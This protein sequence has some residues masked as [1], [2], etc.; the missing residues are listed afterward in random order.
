MKRANDDTSARVYAYGCGAP[1]AGMEAILAEHTLQRAMWD[2][3]CHADNRAER[4]KL[5]LAAADPD[6]GPLVAVLDRFNAE[7]SAAV[8]DRRAARQ[9]ARSKVDTPDLDARIAELSDARKAARKA[10][11]PLMSAW[12]KNHKP[13]LAEIGKAFHADAKQIR[14]Q[15]G[16][17]WGHYNAVLDRFDTARKLAR[18]SGGRPRFSDPMRRDGAL[19]LQI[20]RT[21][22]GLGASMAELMSGGFNALQ[23]SP[24][25][26]V[27][28]EQRKRARVNL[29]F[30]VDAA[31]RRLQPA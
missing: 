21:K 14:Q 22:S 9:K 15:S 23:I 10:L 5:D 26:P 16:L 31:S 13:E 18:K 11:G 27:D 29:R 19:K 3:L 7:I 2:A 25:V 4:A 6:I 8:K 28:I 30:R 1:T 24:A 20:Q 17:F 12:Y